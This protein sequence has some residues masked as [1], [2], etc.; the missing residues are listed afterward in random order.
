MTQWGG[1][2]GISELAV[3]T[4]AGAA[5]LTKDEG[6]LPWWLARGWRPVLAVGLSS[7]PVW[8]LRRQLKEFYNTQGILLISR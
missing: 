5:G 7:A 4:S 3:Q 2:S 1:A 8:P 6:P